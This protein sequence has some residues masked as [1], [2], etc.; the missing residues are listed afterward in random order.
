MLQVRTLVE[1]ALKGTAQ[2]THA[3]L[4]QFGLVGLTDE[5]VLLVHDGEV[6]QYPDGL[7]PATVYRLVFRACHGVQ[8]RQLHLEG[9]RDVG[10]LRDDAAVFHRP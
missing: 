6:R 4:L 5:P 7:A 9:D 1:V 3:L 2:K 10:I 8:L